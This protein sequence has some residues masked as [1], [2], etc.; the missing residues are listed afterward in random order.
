M[1]TSK[2]HE[3]AASVLRQSLV[4]E[5]YFQNTALL[6]TRIGLPWPTMKAYHKTVLPQKATVREQR[7][8]R[9]QNLTIAMF[10]TPLS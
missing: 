6:P 8:Y 9:Y 2:G 1:A 10:T 3:E 5:F 7:Q 4:G